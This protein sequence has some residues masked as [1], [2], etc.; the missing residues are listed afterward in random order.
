MSKPKLYLFIGYP[1]AGKTTTAKV[2]AEQTGAVH[3]W[4]DV[5]RH[6]LFTDPNHSLK[7]SNVLYEQLNT[8]ADSLLSSGKSVAYDTNFNFRSD[9]QKLSDIAAKHAAE[10]IV[11]WI[12]T[13]LEVARQRAVGEHII[14]NDYAM[15]MSNEQFDAIV[16]KL[17][18]PTSDE[19]VIKIDGTKLDQQ[20][21]VSLLN[22]SAFRT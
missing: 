3:L 7:E 5:E 2:V 8:E 1:G 21:I 9:R 17:E 6:K 13:P 15:H 20:Q 16:A 4:A 19:K 22:S 11:L 18:P 14:R 12:T 10:T